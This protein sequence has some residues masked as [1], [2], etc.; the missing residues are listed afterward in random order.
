MDYEVKDPDTC[1]GLCEECGN[2]QCDERDDGS[3]G[4]H[5]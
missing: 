4:G 5:D 2:K 1:D 3:F